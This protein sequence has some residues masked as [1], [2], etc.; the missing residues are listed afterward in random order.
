MLDE[1]ESKHLLALNGVPIPAAQIV[2]NAEEAVA[3]AESN[4]DIPVVVK[5]VGVAHKI[6]VGGD[7][8]QSHGSAQEVAAATLE[9]AGLSEFLSDRGNGRRRSWRSSSLV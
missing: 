6:E 1:I 7:Q 4:W 8:A 5:A 9:M 3:A 2:H